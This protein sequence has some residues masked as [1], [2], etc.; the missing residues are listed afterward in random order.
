MKN[1]FVSVLFFFINRRAL[2]NNQLVANMRYHISFQKIFFHRNL[3]NIGGDILSAV[4]TSILIYEM[5]PD[6]FRKIEI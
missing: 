4:H 5:C 3:T 1:G 6:D 2:R